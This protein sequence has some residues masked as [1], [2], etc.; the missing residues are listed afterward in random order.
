VNEV[1]QLLTEYIAGFSQI[2]AMIVIVIGMIKASWSFFKDTLFQKE[3]LE[4]IIETRLELGHSFSLGLGFLIGSSILKTVVA[5]TWEDIA[6]LSAII[7]IRTLL[8]F[9]LT[10]DTVTSK[11][12]DSHNSKPENKENKFSLKSPKPKNSPAK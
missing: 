8:N 3:S 7:A 10:R 12:E 1:I 5:P 9:F 6:K 4:A 11:P 2:L